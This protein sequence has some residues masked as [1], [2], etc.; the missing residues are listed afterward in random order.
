MKPLFCMAG[1][2]ALTGSLVVGGAAA[3]GAIAAD[4]GASV[5]GFSAGA[6][7]TLVTPSADASGAL[8][9]L[10]TS[11]GY[12]YNPF[13]SQYNSGSLAI[14]GAGGY[15][16]IELQNPVAGNGYIGIFTNAAFDA[17]NLASTGAQPLTGGYAA[18]VSPAV[19]EYS[20]LS[21]A[22]IKVGYVPNG[23][24]SVPTSLSALAG[25]N[26]VALDVPSNYYNDTKVIVASG[27]Y[28]GY[29][30][31][32]NGSQIASQAIPYYAAPTAV[33]TA[34]GEYD[35]LA[36]LANQ[37]LA[38][39]ESAFGGGA[40]GTWL[41]IGLSASQQINF[42]QLSVPTGDALIL[43][44]VA[45]APAP[46]PASLLLLAIPMMALPLLRRRMDKASR[47]ERTC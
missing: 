42:I 39:I 4:V 12:G 28:G 40:G 45:A 20:T 8:G 11:G 22:V 30:S 32:G 1:A 44:S 9:P 18:G 36:P 15:V 23:S 21:Q 16:D 46:E 17:V 33:E 31:V 43:D 37:T 2:L 47:T 19:G 38:G 34:A 6:T 5:L 7:S 26:T 35:S 25:G 14:V 24:T 41:P 3:A 27:S 13:A 29:V 10:A